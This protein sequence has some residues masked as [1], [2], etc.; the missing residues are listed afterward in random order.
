MPFNSTQYLI[1]FLVVLA[2]SWAVAR[3]PRLRLWLLLAASWWFYAS[4]NFW[5]V[6]LLLGSTQADYVAARLIQQS[7]SP[8]L[9]R[10]ILL[11]SVGLNLTILGFFK[12][13]NFFVDNATAL[14][15]FA[16]HPLDL[17]IHHLLL[18]A[19]ISFYTFE[20]ISYVVDVYR[21]HLKAER[22]WHRYA[23]FIAY[24]PHLIAGPIIRPRT[25]LA[26]LH[27]KV[28][29]Q[30]VQVDA[31]F[32]Y[33]A[34]GLVKKLVLADTIG[35]YVD[36]AFAAADPDRLTALA[37]LYGFALQ[38][39]FDFSGYTDVALGCSL[40]L[41]YRLAPNFRNPYAS[42]SITDF[43]RRWHISLSRWLRDYLYIPLGGNRAGSKWGVH[44][45]LMATMLL[46]GLWHGAAWTFVLWGGLHG[47]LL[48][49]ERVFGLGQRLGNFAGGRTALIVR[50]FVVF[51]V[52]VLTWLPFRATSLAQVWA[53]LKALAVGPMPA[54]PALWMA[55]IPALALATLG[56][57]SLVSHWP[58][59][60]W[61][62]GLAMPVKGAVYGAVAT[63][64]LVY[65]SR[66]TTAFIY[67]A[68]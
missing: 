23:M 48:V 67:F 39:F 29:L 51:H 18:P 21:G 61:F 28:T 43:W 47:A 35:V 4:N 49:L 57:Q 42:L 8:A 38:I 31:A 5:L 63:L 65:A 32:A 16:G 62:L 27:R 37:G 68:F 3:L 64:V 56:W 66:G 14:A 7:R 25:F 19:G 22:Y 59:R 11:I 52:V 44:R 2:L 50:R 53:F 6:F 41:G 46:G 58:A 24:F 60:R 34:Q 33:I 20:S 13:F 1:F 17:P 36:R 40:L 9:R 30:P 12:Y 45:N 55:A 26:K 54:V 15:T 10:S